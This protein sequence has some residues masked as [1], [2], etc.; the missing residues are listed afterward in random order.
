[1]MSF[2]PIPTKLTIAALEAGERRPMMAQN[3]IP[4]AEFKTSVSHPTGPHIPPGARAAVVTFMG[5]MTK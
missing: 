4:F 2:F 1:M 3:G 5:S